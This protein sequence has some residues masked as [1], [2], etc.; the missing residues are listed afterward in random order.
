MQEIVQVVM[1]V[2]GAVT[3]SMIFNVR[4]SRIV[5]GGLGGRL[6]L[7]SLSV[8]TGSVWG[9]SHGAFGSYSGGRH[10]V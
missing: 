5:V 8:C 1:A 9:Q 4:G 2:F 7:G 6:C 10:P 3:F